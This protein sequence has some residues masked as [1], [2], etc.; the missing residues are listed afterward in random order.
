MNTTGMTEMGD[1]N[2]NLPTKRG[3]FGRM[4]NRFAITQPSLTEQY[5]IKESEANRQKRISKLLG[6][7]Y[8]PKTKE[9]WDSNNLL[10]MSKSLNNHDKELKIQYALFY[11]MISMLDLK[12]NSTEFAKMAADFK[13]N[14]LRLIEIKSR[15]Y[16]VG[17]NKEYI[18]T[19]EAS[20]ELLD[21]LVYTALGEKDKKAIK[22]L[23]ISI[24]P[25]DKETLDAEI[26]A[27][28]N[29]T[30]EENPMFAAPNA[31]KLPMPNN[32]F[33]PLNLNGTNKRNRRNTR[34]ANRKRRST[35]KNH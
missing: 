16:R 23:Y 9:N 33:V 11:S 19:K 34:R 4:K 3:F 24:I 7:I 2:N 35:R 13:K 17:K 22:D 14:I 18:N 27:L 6:K 25:Q 21:F 29:Y 30:E 32:E 5:A 12:K 1:P 28:R 26:K 10:A 15:E 8:T 20:A 31:S